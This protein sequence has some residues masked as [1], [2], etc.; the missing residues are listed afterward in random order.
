MIPNPERLT[1]ASPIG[2]G[3][4]S[5]NQPNVDNNNKHKGLYLPRNTKAMKIEATNARA[6]VQ[7]LEALEGLKGK[8]A[9]VTMTPSTFQRLRRLE[10]QA[11]RLAER[12]CNGDTDEDAT[13]KEADRILSKVRGIL[14]CDPPGLF[15]NFDPRGYALKI[16]AEHRPEGIYRDWGGYGIIAPEF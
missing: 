7:H 11:H 4:G 12:M 8:G 5:K 13:D 3:Q 10:A 6:F 2:T 1:T 14:Q 9:A 16:Q 15:V